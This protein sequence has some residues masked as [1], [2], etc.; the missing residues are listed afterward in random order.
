MGSRGSRPLGREEQVTGHASWAGE[1]S[2]YPDTSSTRLPGS[3]DTSLVSTGRALP[4]ALPSSMGPPVSERPSYWSDRPSRPVQDWIPLPD[5]GVQALDAVDQDLYMARVSNLRAEDPKLSNR[6][7]WNYERDPFFDKRHDHYCPH[8]PFDEWRP[9]D[10]AARQPELVWTLRD[11]EEGRTY[12]SAAD[13]VQQAPGL[14]PRAEERLMPAP[15][16][17]KGQAPAPQPA[18]LPIHGP[19]PERVLKQEFV[20]P[21]VIDS[22]AASTATGTTLTPLTTAMLPSSPGGSSIVLPPPSMGSMVSDRGPRLVEEIHY[23]P[24]R[25]DRLRPAPAIA[26]SP[27]GM[28]SWPPSMMRVPPGAGYGVSAAPSAAA[29]SVGP[30][31]LGSSAVL[32]PPSPAST[33]FSRP[34]YHL[35]AQAVAPPYGAVAQRAW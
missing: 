29:L 3:S 14:R 28:P 34:S 19:E 35:G 9:G 21:P 4:S 23:E 15:P 22:A 30:S 17:R 18:L 12:S 26:G 7:W 11:L 32:G 27:S 2:R 20:Y 8:D 25:V 33:S 6:P 5:F 24:V 16:L 1:L 10:A 13:G 31:G